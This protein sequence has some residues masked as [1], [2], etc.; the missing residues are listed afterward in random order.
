MPFKRTRGYH[1]SLSRP[2]D[3][4][5]VR[6]EG[7]LPDHLRGTLSRNGP[8]LFEHGGRRHRHVFEGDGAVCAVRIGSESV[9]C[10]HLLVETEACGKGAR[11]TGDGTAASW[12]KRFAANWQKHFK[13]SANTSIW[14]WRRRSSR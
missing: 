7:R 2:H 12:P 4:E 6:I 13:N 3:F 5:P 10:A 11:G 14:R 9:E 8:A 1:R